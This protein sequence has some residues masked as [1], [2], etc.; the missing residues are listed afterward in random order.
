[1]DIYPFD[2]AQYLKEGYQ[3]A[4]IISCPNE[5][6]MRWLVLGLRSRGEVEFQKLAQCLTELHEALGA[7]V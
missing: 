1:M 5:L 6:F 4:Q 3:I 7:C 2:V